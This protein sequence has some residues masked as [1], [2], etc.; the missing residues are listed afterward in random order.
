MLACIARDLKKTLPALDVHA[1]PCCAHTSAKVPSS[2]PLK[3]ARSQPIREDF[4]RTAPLV[5][6]KCGRYLPFEQFH[7]INGKPSLR[8]S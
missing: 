1:Y 4:P 7:R 2:L 8:L 3:S 6:L 5:A